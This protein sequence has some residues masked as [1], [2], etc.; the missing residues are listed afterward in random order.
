MRAWKRNYLTSGRMKN[1]ERR[2]DG[3]CPKLEACIWSSHLQFGTWGNLN[4]ILW[5]QRRT[6]KSIVTFGWILLR[7]MTYNKESSKKRKS[8]KVATTGIL[9]LPNIYLIIFHLILHT[10]SFFY[11]DKSVN[12]LQWYNGWYRRISRIVKNVY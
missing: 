6:M 8:S 10:H 12:V 11:K 4:L 5:R 7:K 1:L 3:P 2:I 9:Y